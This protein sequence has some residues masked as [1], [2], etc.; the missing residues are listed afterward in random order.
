MR[1][2]LPPLNALRAF[3]AAARHMS[4]TRAADELAVTPAA[5][6]QQVRLL[7][8]FLGQPLFRRRNRSLLLT[9]A[10][11]TCLPF[12]REGF[13]RFAEGIERLRSADS[14]GTLAVSVAPS[15]AAKWLVPRV[16]GFRELHPEIDLWVSAAM[17]LVDFARDNVDVAIRDG[18]GHY[19]GLKV[20]RL[21]AECVFPVCSPQLLG[22]AHPLTTPQ[23]LR[24]HTLL[25]DDSSLEDA[26]CPTWAMWLR[27]AGVEGVDGARGLRFNQSSLAIEAAVS[28]RGVV[29]AK[30]ALA[31]DDLAAGRLVKPF[32]MTVPLDFAYYLVA[33]ASKASLPKVAAFR[34]WIMDTARGGPAGRDDPFAG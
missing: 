19:P 31:A 9:D 5:V 28:G 24:H 22:G 6:S 2:T 3:V 8:S 29:L 21:L 14:G 33:P 16:D 23:D 10:A 32:E 27:A 4:F 26:S 18:A 34:G 15:F 12:I 17:E 25:H 7:E 13:E 20:E 1:R 30:S 11:Q